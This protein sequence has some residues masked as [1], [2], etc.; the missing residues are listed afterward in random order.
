MKKIDVISNNKFEIQANCLFFS[1]FVLFVLQEIVLWRKQTKDW[2]K[3][4]KNAQPYA[5]FD[6]K[7]NNTEPTATSDSN[8]DAAN[9]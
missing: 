6:P 1:R 2:D 4:E 3:A 8:G 9:D 7:V 5:Y